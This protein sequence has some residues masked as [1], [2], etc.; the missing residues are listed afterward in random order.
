MFRRCPISVFWPMK[1]RTLPFASISST[2]AQANFSYSRMT[3]SIV[4]ELY[5]AFSSALTWTVPSSASGRL[6]ASCDFD[7]SGGDFSMY[8]D[9]SSL[10]SIP[11]RERLLRTIA[12]YVQIRIAPS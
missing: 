1:F 2:G 8:A 10:P 6:T 7:L 5:S 11:F 9:V 3:D 4:A 12:G